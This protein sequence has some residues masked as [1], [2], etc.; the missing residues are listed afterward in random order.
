M[1][2]D[3][4]NHVELLCN[5]LTFITQAKPL[6]IFVKKESEHTRSAIIDSYIV[7]ANTANL[8]YR[9]ISRSEIGDY[10]RT[11]GDAFIFSP[12]WRTEEI[13]RTYASLSQQSTYFSIYHICKTNDSSSNSHKLTKYCN[14]SSI[15]TMKD[16]VIQDLLS[17]LYVP[18]AKVTKLKNPAIK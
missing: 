2:L 17:D 3:W 5:I 13:E 8:P 11:S 9:V 10:T 1:A 14:F 7:R 6:T 4:A 12:N 15:D 16:V 18:I